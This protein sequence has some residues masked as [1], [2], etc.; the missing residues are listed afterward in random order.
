MRTAMTLCNLNAMH[1]K[2]ITEPRRET[3]DGVNFTLKMI[4]R[5]PPLPEGRGLQK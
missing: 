4:V 3:S 1:S 5:P 2:D